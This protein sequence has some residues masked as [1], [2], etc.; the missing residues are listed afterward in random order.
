MFFFQKNR[1]RKIHVVLD[2]F[3]EKAELLY[4]RVFVE[5][6]EDFFEHDECSVQLF[7]VCSDKALAGAF[8]EFLDQFK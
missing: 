8:H 2:K 4:E 1:L 7:D 3:F 6:F 5:I